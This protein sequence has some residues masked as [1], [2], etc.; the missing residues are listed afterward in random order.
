MAG[1]CWV[2]TAN[3]EHLDPVAVL[4]AVSSIIP[5]IHPLTDLAFHCRHLDAAS[6][7]EPEMADGRLALIATKR[8][9]AYEVVKSPKAAYTIFRRKFLT[10]SPTNSPE[11]AH[12]VV[13]QPK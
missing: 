11:K 1:V 6:S 10:N 2:V 9:E 4:A 3:S 7:R 13:L 5:E 12:L 8:L